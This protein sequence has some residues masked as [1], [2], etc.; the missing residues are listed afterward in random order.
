[1]NKKEEKW[2]IEGALYALRLAKEKGIDYLQ[3][4]IKNVGLFYFLGYGSQHNL[5]HTLCV[6]E[7][8]PVKRCLVIDVYKRQSLR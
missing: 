5:P 8:H 3:E 7:I 2:R 1:M 6:P 4:D